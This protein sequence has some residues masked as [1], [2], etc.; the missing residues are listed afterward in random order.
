MR[1]CVGRGEG[2]R[3]VCVGG[4]DEDVR[5]RVCGWVG[6]EGGEGGVVWGGGGEWLHGQMRQCHVINEE[7][8]ST[9]MNKM[10]RLIS[11]N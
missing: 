4:W 5:V 6:C 1:V 2:V 8:K 10:S 9:Q 11:V 7:G 3:A